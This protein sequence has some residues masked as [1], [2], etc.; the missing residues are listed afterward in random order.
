MNNKA[1]VTTALAV[2]MLATACA[3]SAGE[4]A[5]V[6]QQGAAQDH[7]APATVTPPIPNAANVFAPTDHATVTPNGL[8]VAGVPTPV[9]TF[10]SAQPTSHSATQNGAA[11]VVSPSLFFA[12]TTHARTALTPSDSRPSAFVA[13]VPGAGIPGLFSPTGAFLGLIGPGGLLI[14]DGVLPGRTGRDVCP[15]VEAI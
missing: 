10:S 4:T 5:V 13:P 3:T 6:K 7:P 2:G 9:V 14:G 15:R 1:I 11:P 8:L 12:P